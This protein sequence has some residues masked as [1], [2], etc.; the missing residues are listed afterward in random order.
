MP[1]RGARERELDV[2]DGQRVAREHD[3]DVALTDQR[4]EVLDAAGVDDDRP[5]D[6]GDAPAGRL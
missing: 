5:G 4:G 3:V 1:E 6:D 2:V